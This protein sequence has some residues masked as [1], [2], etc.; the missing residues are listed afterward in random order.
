VAVVG[1]PICTLFHQVE[2]LVVLVVEEERTPGGTAAGGSGN[3]PPTSPPQGN[4]GGFGI[5]APT[6]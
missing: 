6:W 4:P 2:V 1:G 3:T 5:N